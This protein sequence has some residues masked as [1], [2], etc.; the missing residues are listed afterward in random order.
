VRCGVSPDAVAG[1]RRDCDLARRGYTLEW[2]GNELFV[3]GV[4]EHLDCE[5]CQRLHELVVNAEI[6]IS[7]AEHR[8]EGHQRLWRFVAADALQRRQHLEL[9][10]NLIDGLTL[11]YR[12][13]AI[14]LHELGDSKIPRHIAALSRDQ[15]YELLDKLRHARLSRVIAWLDGLAP[16]P[17]LS[18]VVVDQRER[19]VRELW[20]V[21]KRQLQRTGQP[22]PDCITDYDKGELDGSKVARTVPAGM[23]ASEPEVM[24]DTLPSCSR[25]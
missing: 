12:H 3:M 4:N 25:T 1:G 13:R 11:L 16:T 15:Q 5:R 6:L 21:Q 10:R 8:I 18:N 23:L 2:R 24:C 20:E 22:F 9:E 17:P 14:C 19:A 7:E